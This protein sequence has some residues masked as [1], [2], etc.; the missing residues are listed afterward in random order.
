MADE[1]ILRE[2]AEALHR[3]PMFESVGLEELLPLAEKV[4]EQEPGRGDRL[5][6]EG[7]EAREFTFVIEGK[8]KVVKTKPSGKE[9]TLGV[10]GDGDIVGHVAAFREIGYPGSAIALTDA[11]IFQID[12]R[13]FVETVADH[14]DLMDGLLQSMMERNFH[15]V[16]R[17]DELTAQGTDKRLALLFLKLARKLGS[18]QTLPNGDRGVFIDV[19]LSRSDLAELVGTRVETVIRIMSAWDDEGPVETKDD[20]F[21]VVDIEELEDLAPG[22]SAIFA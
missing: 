5:W 9:I 12:R 22:E 18:V 17:I 7:E 10:F 14:P 16:Q 2:R 21:L 6:L 1:E 11:R 19:A 20:G 8:V 15:L 4:R 3:V 13:E